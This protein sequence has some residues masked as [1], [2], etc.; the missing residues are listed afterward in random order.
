MDI[1][2]YSANCTGVETNCRY[3]HETAVADEA[4]L[5]SAVA[6]DYVCVAYKD[7][8]RPKDNFL[9]T[10]SAASSPM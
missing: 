9:S 6:R 1:K 7:S 2:L 3:P 8:Y 5:L 10:T 4:S